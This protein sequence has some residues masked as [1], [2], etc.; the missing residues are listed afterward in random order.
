M[1]ADESGWK[2]AM[3]QGDRS[4]LPLPFRWLITRRL[5][6]LTLPIDFQTW[7]IATLF[8]EPVSSLLSIDVIHGGHGAK[9]TT[10]IVQSVYLTRR[11]NVFTN[12]DPISINGLTI[13]L[14]GIELHYSRC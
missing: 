4:V 6:Q 1:K 10:S 8:P 3:G 5:H 12:I 7:L 9:G 13:L 11:N 2:G 14:S